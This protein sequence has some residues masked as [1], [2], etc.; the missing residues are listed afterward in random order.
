MIKLPNL[1]VMTSIW[2]DPSNSSSFSIRFVAF[3]VSL[4][5]IANGSFDNYLQQKNSKSQEKMKKM[6]ENQMES[7]N[8]HKYER[9]D[10]NVVLF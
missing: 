1:L 10:A 4:Y 8:G 5:F 3:L 9:S 7:F 6:G 2:L